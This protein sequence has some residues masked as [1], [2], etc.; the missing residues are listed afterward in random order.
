MDFSAT[1]LFVE[2]LFGGILFTFAVSP[3]LIALSPEAR[4]KKGFLPGMNDWAEWKP[5]IILAVAL[6]YAV[7][8]AGNRLAQELYKRTGI[9]PVTDPDREEFELRVRDHSE[10]AR[11]FV[12][13]HKTYRKVLRAASFSS[14]LFLVSMLV[15]GGLAGGRRRYR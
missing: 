1:E 6:L 15:Y 13:R 7:G 2:I 10:V 12:E 14:F 3:I 9:D 8:I 4:Q 11:D 5:W